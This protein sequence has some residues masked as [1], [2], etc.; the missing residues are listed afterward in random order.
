MPV[1]GEYLYMPLLVWLYLIIDLMMEVEK[2]PLLLR[3]LFFWLYWVVYSTAAEIALY[4]I[5]GV[6][7]SAF[8]GH[9]L[10]P[11]VLILIA[12]IGT[13]TVLQSLTFK[14]GG[15]KV[16]DLSRYL[17]DYRRKVLTS[18]AALKI[19]FERRRVLEQSGLILRKMKYV[20]GDEA[21]KSGMRRI[22]AEVLL[23]GRDAAKLQQEI[24]KVEQLSTQN[25]ASFGTIVAER[26][27]QA[28]PEWV[29]NFLAK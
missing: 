7:N 19:R 29:R 23:A 22:Y 1:P 25:G 10:P 11:A 28:D 9:T 8:P 14:I 4:F 2:L 17:D 20:D 13:T 26:I 3:N 5:G 21:S 16:L 12:I 6:A 24:A 27:A 18:S 15:K